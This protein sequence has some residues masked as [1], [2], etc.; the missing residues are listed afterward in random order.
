M[1]R[2]TWMAIQIIA[3]LVLSSGGLY[4]LTWGGDVD[5]IIRTID[6]QQQKIFTLRA[7][8]TQKRQT[9]L[10]KRP[11]LSSGQV[12]FTRPDRIHWTYL[13][14]EPMEIALD[15]KEIWI[16]TPRRAEAERFSLSRSR[17]LVQ[18]L[19]PLTSIFQKPF[20]QLSGEYDPVYQELRNQTYR[21]RLQPKK[22]NLQK[23][24][25]GIDLWIDQTSGAILVFDMTEASGD[26]LTLEFKHLQF[27]P[28]LTEEDLKIKIPPSVRVQE[29]VLP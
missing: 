16:Y 20:A 12:K 6:E 3:A 8:F 2:K 25:A 13:Q 10:A 23:F 5:E 17:R 24:L 14:P 15:G 19:E 28:P 18:Y 9:A 26:R 1:N 29:Q 22:E 7:D 27:N 21:F 4:S 11:L